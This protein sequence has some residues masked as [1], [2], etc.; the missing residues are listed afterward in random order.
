MEMHQLVSRGFQLKKASFLVSRRFKEST[1]TIEE[2]KN[3][4]G[5]E[6]ARLTRHTD[7]ERKNYTEIKGGDNRGN[8]A[9]FLLHK[10]DS[11]EGEK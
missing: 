3:M 10:P 9:G 2:E 8:I 1:H 6:S 7:E 11:L 5:K 4:S